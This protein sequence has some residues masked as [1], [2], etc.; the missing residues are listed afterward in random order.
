MYR[1]MFKVKG[2][3]LTVGEVKKEFAKEYDEF[4]VNITFEDMDDNEKAL[5]AFRGW[6]EERDGY[7]YIV[8]EVC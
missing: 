2:T 4:M 7:T 5:V 8:E 1:D 6:A 3:N